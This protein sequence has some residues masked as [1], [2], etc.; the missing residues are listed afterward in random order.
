MRLKFYWSPLEKAIYNWPSR[1]S[2]IIIGHWSLSL[3]FGAMNLT[4]SSTI[5]SGWRLNMVSTFFWTTLE[6]F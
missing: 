5:L 4:L 2:D 3:G 6:E 1:E